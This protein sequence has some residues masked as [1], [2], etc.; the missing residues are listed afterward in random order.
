MKNKNINNMK[1]YRRSFTF[2]LTLS[3]LTFYFVSCNSFL[4]EIPSGSLTDQSELTSSESGIALKTG[5]YRSLAKW[6]SSASD[7][8]NFLPAT[9]EY[10]TGKAYTEDAHVQIWRY[11]TDQVTG[12]LLNNFN[13]A[14][15]N[16]FDGVR[17]C[18]LAL[19]KLP[20]I[21]GMTEQE[22]GTALAEVRT[23]RAWYYFNLVRYFGDVPLITSV[24]QGNDEIEQKR[25]SLKEIY[26]QVIIPD[27]EF[28]TSENF[29]AD[30]RSV[31]GRVTKDVARVILA[32]VYLTCAGYPY[33]EINTDPAKNW[34][35]DGLWKQSGYPI[36]TESSISFLRKAKEQLDNLYGKYRLGTYDDLRNPAMNNQGEAIFQAQ[37]L[38]G[39]TDNSVI[40][41]SLPMLS[42]ISMFGDEYGTFVPSL[43]YYNSYSPN[44]K[45]S[46]DRQM[47]FFSDIR[48]KKY[49]PSESYKVTFSS[50][51]LF[52]YYDED[53]IKNTGK[54]GLNWTFYRYADVL[55]MLTEVNWSLRSL[56]QSISGNE[57][58]KGINE[59][60]KRAMLPELQ[61]SEVNLLT[62]FS[63][64]AYE[65]VFENKMLWDMRRT[66]KALVDGE[67]S[68]SAIED[69]IGHRP[70]G[71]SF[72]FSAKHLLSP[73][74]GNEIQYNSKME[75]N[76]GYLPR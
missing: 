52:K 51:H 17:D 36:N 25:V 38:A 65:L 33:Q 8:G 28:S 54:S 71:F 29:L 21:S 12:D 75:Q 68:F 34:S 56:G 32:D 67:G 5:P 41:T 19:T 44:D 30:G 61:E 20:E 16:W 60:R 55:L 18:N 59:V 24:I 35:V 27:L 76:F 57:I 39:T 66:R 42:Q 31:D 37:F 70:I 74:S 43:S 15:N 63:E 72:S 49:D 47:F 2:S 40:P 11:Q 58:T 26:D 62:I 50:P 73:I 7:W 46:Q 3:L 1:R 53:A 9:F 22:L 64:R 10:P 69:F 13:H 6:V 45:R 23:L 48:S 4:E 14:W